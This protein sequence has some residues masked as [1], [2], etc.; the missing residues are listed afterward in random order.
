MFEPF[1]TKAPNDMRSSFVIFD[2]LPIFD[3]KLSGNEWGIGT[4]QQSS[5]ST[6]MLHERKA[7]ELVL[8][9][10]KLGSL[11]PPSKLTN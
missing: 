9:I 7:K 1:G 4:V 5:R 10:I 8:D 11:E 2:C 6:V 3:G